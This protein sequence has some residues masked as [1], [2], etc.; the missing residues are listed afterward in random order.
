M[1]LIDLLEGSALLRFQISA[2]AARFVE[3][4]RCG[5][6]GRKMSSAEMYTKGDA[7]ALAP[8]R[9]AWN[10]SYSVRA[11]GVVQSATHVSVLCE[12]EKATTDPSL[13]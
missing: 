4:Y 8:D 10:V 11:V 2:S 1:G 7:S 9:E 3:M 6:N 5:T 12:A 13:D